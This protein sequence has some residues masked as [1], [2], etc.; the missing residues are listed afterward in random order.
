MDRPKTAVFHS[1]GRPAVSSSIIFHFDDDY[2]IGNISLNLLFLTARPVP[3][4]LQSRRAGRATPSRRRRTPST[5]ALG[6]L[7]GGRSSNP[8]PALQAPPVTVPGPAPGPPAAGL[9]GHMIPCTAG[10][11]PSL[12]GSRAVVVTATISMLCAYGSG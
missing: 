4:S 10:S 8:F 7:L 2:N 6:L 3:A 1:T 11:V 5:V 12:G 9:P